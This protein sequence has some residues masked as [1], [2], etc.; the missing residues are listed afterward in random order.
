M[1]LSLNASTS[2]STRSRQRCRSLPYQYPTQKKNTSIPRK[3][4]SAGKKKLWHVVKSARRA[5]SSTTQLSSLTVKAVTSHLLS[6]RLTALRPSSLSTVP[7]AVYKSRVINSS[8]STGEARSAASF[9]AKA[10]LLQSAVSAPRSSYPLTTFVATNVLE[11]TKILTLHLL[12]L[13]I[14]IHLQSRSNN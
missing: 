1:S 14:L 3:G 13:W 10:N 2:R 8:T 12:L 11:T 5:S 7:S 9:A 6:H 4:K